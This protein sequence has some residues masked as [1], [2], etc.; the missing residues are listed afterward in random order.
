MLDVFLKKH[1]GS[2]LAGYFQKL[3]VFNP[4]VEYLHK[5]CLAGRNT[6]REPF[7]QIRTVPVGIDMTLN[8][9]TKLNKIWAARSRKRLMLEDS[10]QLCLQELPMVLHG[11]LSPLFCKA[12]GP[13]D[14]HT[15]YDL[16]Q[17]FRLSYCNCGKRYSKK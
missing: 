2:S 7:F 3:T 1:W 14:A 12:H 9:Q 6:P 16:A 4:Y 17:S 5:W 10:L 13:C 15:V 8:K 11:V